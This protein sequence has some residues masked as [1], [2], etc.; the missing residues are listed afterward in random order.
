MTTH[1]HRYPQAPM[2]DFLNPPKK[3]GWRSRAKHEIV[4]GLRDFRQAAGTYDG[5]KQIVVI[6]AWVLVVSYLFGLPFV[7]MIRW[8]GLL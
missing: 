4:R 7:L 1:H 6:L 2:H 8:A 3:P 5:L